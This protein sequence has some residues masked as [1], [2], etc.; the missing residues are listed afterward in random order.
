MKY[1]IICV[2]AALVCFGI[3]FLIAFLLRKRLKDS[4]KG[5]K[6]TIITLIIGIFLM[7]I[8]MLIYMSIYSHSGD[9][10]KS[11]MSGNADVVVTEI[12]GGYYFDGPST[13][14]A[15][16]FYA[17]AKV[18]CEAYAPLMLKLAEDGYDCFLA[19]MPLNFAIFGSNK[20]DKFIQAYNYETWIM[21]GHSMG[22]IVASTYAEEHKDIID[23]VILL[24]SYTTTELD[25]NIKV[26]SIY[27][28]E[29]GCLDIEEYEKNKSNMSDGFVELIIEGGNHAQF[30]DYGTQKGDGTAKISA[31]EQIAQTVEAIV[32]CFNK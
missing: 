22:G 5:L 6:I 12:D 8:V 18:E 17:G 11:A 7:V 15:I 21:A 4:K 24:A 16:V 32:K 3:G 25:D 29:D 31:E 20:A 27:G 2:V 26:C 28:S 13:T 30:G 10:A 23:G 14:K 19:D 1:I 9:K